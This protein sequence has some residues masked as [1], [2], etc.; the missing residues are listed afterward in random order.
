MGSSLPST[1]ADPHTGCASRASTE[2]ATCGRRQDGLEHAK[3][4]QHDNND[5]NGDD[6]AHYAVTA[7]APA[8]LILH[9]A[10]DHW[11][12]GLGNMS[13]AVDPPARYPEPYQH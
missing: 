10:R 2:R 12:Y 13:L 7:H 1:N 11:R 8:R 6:Q 4:P 3:E 5:H 9:A